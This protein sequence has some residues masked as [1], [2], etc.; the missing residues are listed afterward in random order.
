MQRRY[1]PV[2]GL[3]TVGGQTMQRITAKGKSTNNQA[4]PSQ[5]KSIFDQIEYSLERLPPILVQLEYWIIRLLL[6]GLL[7]IAAYDL[8]GEQARTSHLWR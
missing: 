1:V 3:L 5:L 2:R 6:F 8:L 7:L 4:P